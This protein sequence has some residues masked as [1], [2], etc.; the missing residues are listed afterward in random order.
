MSLR[1]QKK[2]E[3]S[4][5]GRPRSFDVGRALD[6]ALQVFRRKGYEGASLS[7]LTKAMGINRPSLYA[8]FGD[9]ET[10][11]RKAL[12]RYEMMVQCIM[13]EALKNKTARGVVESL[14]RRA[15]EMQTQPGSPPGCLTVHGALACGDGSKSIRRELTCRRDQAEAVI[16]ERFKRA[17]KERD[18]PADCNP[19]DLARYVATVMQGMAVQ[20]AGGATRSELQRVVNTVLRAWPGH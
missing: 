14:L 17:K 7:D 16:R 10:L 18:L 3:E 12:D 11:F 8:A 6:Q 15:V 19:A 4:P 20:A 2:A 5:A 1:T 9:K 13:D